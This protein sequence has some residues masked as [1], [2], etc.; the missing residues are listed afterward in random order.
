MSQRA[1]YLMILLTILTGTT[2]AQSTREAFGKNRVQHKNLIW[3]FFSTENFDIYFYDGGEE[4]AR[5]AA[6]FMEEEFNRITDILGY[7]PY[8]KTKIFLYNSAADLQQSNKG[9][10]EVPYTIGGQ[11]NF[12]KLQVEIAH[13]GTMAAFK[14][15]LI[16]K[17]TKLLVNDM[18]FGGSLSDMFQSAY[19]LSLPDWF[20]DGAALYIAYGWDVRMDD[21]MRDYFQNEKF[22]KL[23]RLSGDEAKIIGQSI[24]NY[25]GLKFGRSNISNVLNLTRIIRNEENSIAS[26]LGVPFRRFLADWQSYYMNNSTTI[27]DNYI[28]PNED[29]EIIKRVGE[30]QFNHIKISP[31]S[32]HL[33]YTVN[34]R[35]RY[36]VM[37]RNLET[38]KENKILVNGFRLINQEVD[39]DIPIISWINE[40]TLAI[41]DVYKGYYRLSQY[42]LENKLLISKPMQRFTQIKDIGFNSNG[43]LAVIS[44]DVEGRNDLFLLSMRRNAVR[45]L[46]DDIYDDVN[47]QF[48]P[49][50]DAVVFSSNRVSDSLQVQNDTFDKI[51]QN[52]NL[53]LYDLDTTETVVARLTNTLSKDTKPKPIDSNTIFYLSDQK[54]ITNIYRYVVSDNV[55]DQVS[56]YNTSLTDYDLIPAGDGLAFIML[57]EGSPRLYYSDTF[58]KGKSIF[59]PQ[60]LRQDLQQAKFV[61]DRLKNR[62]TAPIDIEEDTTV[63]DLNDFLIPFSNDSTSDLS[64]DDL[65]DT[66]NYIFEDDEEVQTESFLSNFMQAETEAEIIG[67]VAYET[68][69]HAEN[70][71]TSFVIDQLRGFGILLETQMND[72]LEDQRFYG[73][74]L[75]ISDLRSGDFFGEYELLKYKLDLK[76]RY[77]R[78]SLWYRVPDSDPDLDT[79]TNQKY[80]LNKFEFGAQLPLNT[81]TRIS[82]LPFLANTRYLEANPVLVSR[83]FAPTPDERDYYAGFR[84]EIVFDNSITKG[85]NIYEG[86]RARAG[87]HQWSGITARTNGFTNFFADI[88]HHQKIHRELT[89]AVRGY[90]GKYLGDQTPQFLLGGMDNWLLKQ[91][92]NDGDNDPLLATTGFNNSNLLFHQFIPLRGY[93]YNKLNGKNVLAFNAEL[94]VPIIRYLV[95]GPIQSNFLRNFMLIG[96]YDI[97]SA[98]TGVSPFNRE[99]AVNTQTIR[100][101]AFEAT[102]RNSQSPWLTSFGFGLRTV[103]LGYYLKFDFAKPIEDFEVGKLKFFLT[104]GHEF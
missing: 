51:S 71:V 66:E 67:P 102:F 45:R 44:A 28:S 93:N 1:A 68:R 88:R 18:M 29:A 89:L 94:R 69:Y 60:T 15:E 22:R 95:R 91:T 80:I 90:Y 47:P 53:F 83:G 59:T 75:A 87:L 76:V 79:E 12:I 2:M 8:A 42:S 96:F 103:M 40:T 56:N 46:T 43:N 36:K 21:F 84:A 63:S 9:L 6:E 65:I 92:D 4:N 19:L 24:W 77:D 64:L 20:M 35:G 11:T 37:M 70:I 48:L 81:T 100:R 58:D 13:P 72:M 41:I 55:F 31:D 32:K 5:L 7:A 3:R 99:N 25:I 33:A 104:I 16:F 86:T 74:V 61:S 50:T 30:L 17:T 26:T 23:K 57:H 98:W 38:G 85:L 34:D 101:D 27:S 39:E 82:F 49:G 73:G 97:G 52:F 14:E 54:G 78:K 62:E 10:Y